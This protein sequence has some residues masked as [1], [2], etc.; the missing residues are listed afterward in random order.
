MRAQ[1]LPTQSY[2]LLVYHLQHPAQWPAAALLRKKK[3][4]NRDPCSSAARCPIRVY[5]AT[6]NRTQT[7]PSPISTAADLCLL[8]NELDLAPLIL[9]PTNHHLRRQTY[10]TLARSVQ[11]CCPTS[12]PSLFYLPNDASPLPH[13]RLP[14]PALHDSRILQWGQCS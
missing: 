8:W 6:Q 11:F 13:P 10:I 1:S 7:N 9:L 5:H 14:L 2:S 12:S 4:P 3:S